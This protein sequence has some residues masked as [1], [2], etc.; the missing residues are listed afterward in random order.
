LH[1]IVQ[2]SLKGSGDYDFT[3]EAFRAALLAT[4]AGRTSSLEERCGTS[5]TFEEALMAI[6]RI[7]AGV[8]K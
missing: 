8:V 7:R 4:L 3:R 6:E 2:K 5:E 1:P